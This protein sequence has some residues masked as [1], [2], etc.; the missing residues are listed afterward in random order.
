MSDNPRTLC[1]DIGGT[2]IK[3]IT[4]DASGRPK[5]ERARMLTPHPSRPVAVL[6]VIRRMLPGQPHFDRI[7]VGFPGV[8]INGVV[9]NQDGVVSIKADGF[10]PIGGRPAAIDV[11]HD[12]H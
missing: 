4:L 9:Q 12:F 8:I 3:M 1:I 10:E 6:D 7:S 2:G 5:T 11:S